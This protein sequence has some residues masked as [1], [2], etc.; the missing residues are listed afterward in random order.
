MVSTS[1]KLSEVMAAV[2]HELCCPV[3]LEE[4]TEPKCLPNC[5]HNVC[6]RCLE[7]MTWNNDV[8]TVECPVCRKESSIP[9][10]GVA[11]FPKNHLI[12]CLVEKAPSCRSV[13]CSEG[14][15]ACIK[16]LLK[17]SKE[18]V[19]DLKSVLEEMETRRF[20]AAKQAN[21]LKLEISSAAQSI[22]K[23]V[24]IQEKRLLVELDRC[25]E[26]YYAEATFSKHKEKLANLLAKT[27]GCVQSIEH[28]LEKGKDHEKRS[29][30]FGQHLEQ[31]AKIAGVQI[32]SARRQCC[33]N[34]ELSYSKNE[35]SQNMV[36]GILGSVVRKEQG[37]SHKNKTNKTVLK[38]IDGKQINVPNFFPFALSVSKKSGDFA[39][40]DA[41]NKRVHIFDQYGN[42]LAQFLFI[43]GDFWDVTYSHNDEIV[44]LNRESNSL[45]H[46]DRSGNFKRKFPTTSRPK[47]KFTF[48]S[49]DPAGHLLVTSSPRYKE[50]VDETIA[51]VLIYSPLGKLE[52]RFGEG[53]LSSPKRAVWL[54][55]Q[56]FVPDADSKSVKVFGRAGQFLLEIGHGLLDDLAGITTDAKRGHVLVCDCEGYAVYVYDQVGALVR[57]IRTEAPPVEI[58]LSKDGRSLV[59]CF[60]EEKVKCLQILT[61]SDSAVTREF[62]T[63]V[64]EPMDDRK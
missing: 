21:N 53:Q 3:C 1:A 4:F 62:E 64:V 15:P 42:H 47:V 29:L 25:M 41:E 37:K 8:R 31:L 13:C 11:A 10:G 49:S 14:K 24:Q 48:L 38:H 7:E 30:R 28:C 33:P 63:G 57:T 5:V 50:T 26:K 45:L 20:L 58:A 9:T 54:K 39:V 52:L 60:D 59:V 19:G 35:T 56:Y 61:Y 18:N 22:I 46:Y 44:I 40:L 55:G 12:A 17:R 6:Q 51:C 34:F 16:E 23:M 36:E 43:F 32:I 27:T 2:V